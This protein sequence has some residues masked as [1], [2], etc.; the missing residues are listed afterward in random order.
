MYQITPC[1]YIFTH[2]YLNTMQQGIQSLHVVGNMFGKYT[3]DTDGYKDVLDW[4]QN[5][6]VV[7]ILNGGGSPNFAKNMDDAFKIASLYALPYVNFV[8]PDLYEQTSAFGF[9]LT[10]QTVH[11]IESERD[12]VDEPNR[13]DFDIIKFLKQFNSAR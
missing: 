6:K 2:V 4:A 7:R 10:P 12:Y 11:N 3:A 5:Y 8:E 9:I 1:A 13:D